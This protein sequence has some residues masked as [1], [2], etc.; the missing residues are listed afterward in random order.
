MKT[1][2]QLENKELKLL[3]TDL[4]SKTIIELGQNKSDKEI[5]VLVNSLA[6]DL[7]DD[8]DTLYFLD[9]IKSFKNGVRR[10]DLFSLNVKTYYK[11][12]KTHQNL[13]WQ[14]ESKEDFEKDKRLKYRS[15]KN[16]GLLTLK[17]NLLNVKL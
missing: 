16:T 17:Q 8:F 1:I 13:I 7:K 14:N 6:E 15:K 2:K 10:T 5:V 3:C 12:I 9:I 4:I 11:W